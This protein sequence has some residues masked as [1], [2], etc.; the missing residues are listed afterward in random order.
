MTRKATKDSRH[1][2]D[3][4]Q[5]HPLHP[6]LELF[7]QAVAEILVDRC[8]ARSQPGSPPNSPPGR[9]SQGH[10]RRNQLKGKTH[11]RSSA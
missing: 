8:L 7:A 5:D 3:A 2:G 11:G 10:G 6:A 9:R 1:N 4:I